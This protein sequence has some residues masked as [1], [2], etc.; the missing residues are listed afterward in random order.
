MVETAEREKQ[1]SQINHKKPRPS[2]LRKLPLLMM[3]KSKRFSTTHSSHTTPTPTMTLQTKNK[4]QVLAKTILNAKITCDSDA[5]T[6]AQD[7]ERHIAH[8]ATLT[9]D[10]Y[11]PP[12][13]FANSTATD[14]MET[15]QDTNGDPVN[16]TIKQEDET[17]HASLDHP[18]PCPSNHTL[19]QG[20]SNKVRKPK[21]TEEK[22]S[23][24][25]V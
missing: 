18:E 1:K 4:R 11:T 23:K 16:G 13:T 10:D 12:P 22:H 19:T 5:E 25:A 8:T 20:E 24:R 14:I 2:R 3:T 9:Q 21:D 6:E 17:L 15:Q 7:N